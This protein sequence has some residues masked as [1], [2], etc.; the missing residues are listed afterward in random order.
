M[1]MAACAHMLLYCTTK[2][3]SLERE[4]KRWTITGK[5][6]MKDRNGWRERKVWAT[7]KKNWIE[8]IRR[9]CSFEWQHMLFANPPPLHTHSPVRSVRAKCPSPGFF[10]VMMSPGKTHSNWSQ[11][12]TTPTPIAPTLSIVGSNA[13]RQCRWRE[14]NVNYHLNKGFMQWVHLSS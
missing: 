1:L 4:R 2:T 8:P 14:L 5:K 7:D 10:P 3:Q 9:W 12:T 13:R 6:K 11:V